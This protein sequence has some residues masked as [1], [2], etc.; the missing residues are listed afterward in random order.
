MRLR[1]NDG[2]TL[3][4]QTQHEFTDRATG[5]VLAAN[6][7]VV[8]YEYRPAMPDALTAWRYKLDH[9]QGGKEQFTATAELLAA[10]LVSWD[11]ETAAGPAPL[12]VEM[13]RRVP[14]PILHQI[15]DAVTHW[16]PEESVGNSPPASGSP[17]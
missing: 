12:T 9:A 6:L 5:K 17:S 7:P 10:H 1:I 8:S 16:S 14:E 4:G 3:R 11:V 13:I 15:L 2:Y